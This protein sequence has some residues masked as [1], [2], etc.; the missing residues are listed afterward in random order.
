M[1]A[2]LPGHI[3]RSAKLAS[4]VIGVKTPDIAAAIRRDAPAAVMTFDGSPA[5]AASTPDLCP[6][7]GSQPP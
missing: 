7:A 1:P 3:I 2:R 4:R 5:I 6:S